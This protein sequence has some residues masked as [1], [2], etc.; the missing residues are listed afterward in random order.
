MVFESRA[1]MHD[2]PVVYEL[3]LAPPHM[4]TDRE[5]LAATHVLEGLD[6]LHICGGKGH[7][8]RFVALQEIEAEVANGKG[9]F[10]RKYR[11]LD[12]I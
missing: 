7:A 5:R 12:G 9:L 3:H 1:A 8:G 10:V 11:C 4:E 2:E 6:S